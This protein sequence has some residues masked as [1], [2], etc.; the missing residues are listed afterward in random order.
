MIGWLTAFIDRPA[1]DD[2]VAESFWLRVTGTTLSP[3]RGADGGF[4]TFVPAEGDSAL[5]LQRVDDGPGGCHLDLHVDESAGPGWSV[6]DVAA[7]AVDLGAVEVLAE[8]GLVVLRSPGGLPFCVVRWHGEGRPAL[9][10]GRPPV[11]AGQLCVDV[12]APAFDAE[13]D[14]WAA[15]TGWPAVQAAL[16]G[17]VRIDVPPGRGLRLLLQR[18]AASEPG[19]A[20]TA[21]LD[22]STSER[23]VA[24]EVHAALGAT[25]VHEG[26]HWTTLAD[27][28][29]HPYC[30]VDR[31]APRAV[32][33][34]RGLP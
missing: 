14:F 27:P 23:R 20:V 22:L 18:R 1:G 4:A 24:V 32:D 7:R 3:R 21:H 28:T 2:G 31:P 25:V 11:L 34:T 33:A 15:F 17:F 5:R 9:P 30:L 19:D 12:P 10:A 6:P 8:D 26:G 29:G 13:R 16:P